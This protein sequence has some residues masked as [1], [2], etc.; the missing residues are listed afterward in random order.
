M[1]NIPYNQL[2]NELCKI[3]SS[4]RNLADTLIPAEGTTVEAAPAATLE[5]SLELFREFQ[6]AENVLRRQ[7]SSGANTSE[8]MGRFREQ[9]KQL[10]ETL[11]SLHRVLCREHV[12]LD[13]ERRLVTAASEWTR[14]S[15][16]TL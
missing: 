8:D 16:Q 3:N 11:P 2:T 1:Y 7:L 5:Q 14:S 10:Q 12:R 13:R 15:R 4:L 6:N 9:V